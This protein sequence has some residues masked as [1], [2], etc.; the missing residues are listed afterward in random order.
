VFFPCWWAAALLGLKAG[1]TGR[2]RLSR[3]EKTAWQASIVLSIIGVLLFLL[4]IIWYGADPNGAKATLLKYTGFGSPENLQGASASP[5]PAA[6]SPS[7]SLAVV[8]LHTACTG[9]S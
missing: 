4:F 9:S 6:A 8:S 3:Q 2:S 5:S 1:R 7:P